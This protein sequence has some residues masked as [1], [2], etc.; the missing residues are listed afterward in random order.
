MKKIIMAVTMALAVG[1]QAD[2]YI[3]FYAGYGF[4]KDYASDPSGNIPLLADGE[5]AMVQIIYAGDNGEP[6]YMSVVSNGSGDVFALSA[7]GG[8]YGDDVVI[9]S[10]STVPADLGAGNWSEFAL[11]SKT[12]QKPYMGN[13]LV[14]GR[15]YS[16][17]G[18]EWFQSAVLLATDFDMAAIPPSP[19]ET[20]R[21]DNGSVDGVTPAFVGLQ[22]NGDVYSGVIPEPATLE[23]MGV[24]ASGV[25]AFRRIFR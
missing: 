10:F 20:F 23:L 16:A 8:V 21:L 15:I 9:D 13:G 3:N 14:Y 4:S 1:A 17:T 25:F 5:Q 2:F 12:I 24:L 22:P 7:A 11:F 6:D 18:M 19:P